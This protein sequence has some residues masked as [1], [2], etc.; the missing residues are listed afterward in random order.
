M[1][2]MQ[3]SGFSQA[4][5]SLQRQAASRAPVSCYAAAAQTLPEA[6]TSAPAQPATERRYVCGMK[7]P[8]VVVPATQ[9]LLL[10]C[11]DG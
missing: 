3:S 10:Q 8:S 4:A 7:K 11:L 6:S 1:L 2:H 5:G 9:L